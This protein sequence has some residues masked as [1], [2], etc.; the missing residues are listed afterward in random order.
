MLTQN[1]LGFKVVPRKRYFKV[2]LETL[3]GM[4]FKMGEKYLT[5][6]S[7][8]LPSVKEG[9]RLVMVGTRGTKRCKEEVVKGIFKGEVEDNGSSALVFKAND[10]DRDGVVFYARAKDAVEEG[11]DEDLDDEVGGMGGEEE[12]EEGLE[13]EIV[14]KKRKIFI[15]D[16]DMEDVFEKEEEKE[17]EV[18]E[19]GEGGGVE[20]EVVK[21]AELKKIG[22]GDEEMPA[23]PDPVQITQSQ[24]TVKTIKKMAPPSSVEEAL[25]QVNIMKSLADACERHSLASVFEDSAEFAIPML[26]GKWAGFGEELENSTDNMVTGKDLKGKLKN[27]RKTPGSEVIFDKGWG[28]Y[29]GG[30]ECFVQ[31]D[32]TGLR[33]ALGGA[34]RIRWDR[35]QREAREEEEGEEGDGGE[36]AVAAVAVEGEGAATEGEGRSTLRK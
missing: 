4:E 2:D 23:V 36:A 3:D 31:R 12:E 11:E 30:G 25:A 7:S 5:V 13:D 8:T 33:A 22:D 32:V 6:A 20:K 10:D 19:G 21:E 24:S 27:D 28:A 16:E 26:G 18:G 34:G 14:R 35:Y 1:K 9:D 17:E 29:Y 15:D